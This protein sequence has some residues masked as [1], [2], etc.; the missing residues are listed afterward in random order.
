[1]ADE[2]MF[3]VLEK[4]FDE[5]SSKFVNTLTLTKEYKI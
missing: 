3:S 1:M 4:M 2:L 5:V